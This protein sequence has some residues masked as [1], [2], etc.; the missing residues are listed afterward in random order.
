MCAEAETRGK[1]R[2]FVRSGYGKNG[3]FYITK[4][5][6]KSES[7]GKTTTLG[8]CSWIYGKTA[9]VLGEFLNTIVSLE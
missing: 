1:K 7:S 2:S 8:F 9:A 4:F 5:F 3:A 6:V